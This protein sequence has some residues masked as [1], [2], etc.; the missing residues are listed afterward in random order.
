[1]AIDTGLIPLYEQKFS[2]LL[3]LKLQQIRAVLRGRVSEQAFAGAKL[4]SPL[5]QMDPIVM[6]A[7]EGRYAPV[8]ITPHTFTRRWV[9]PNDRSLVQMVDNFDLLKTNID[10]QSQ[11]VMDAAAAAARVYDDFIIAAFDAAATIGADAGSLSTESFD[12]AFSIA[13]TF[14]GSGG[15]LGLTVAKLNE[16]RRMLEHSHA[17]DDGGRPT[18]VI[19]SS[20]HADLRNQAQV[21]SSDFNRNGG[22][23]TNGV[24]TE[25][26][27]FDIVV[28]ERLPVASNIRKTFAFV[29]SGVCL[30]VWQDM[31]TKISQR[32]DLESQPWQ[33]YTSLS[34]GATRTQNGKVV[35]INCADTI[36]ADTPA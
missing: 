14:G 21:V 18:L 7:P 23:L 29:K 24:V 11:F 12:T 17:L 30:G 5:Q 1:M 9:A 28:S 13:D 3:E 22:V 6:G 32:D 8:K 16:A 15:S 34:A 35:R 2:T 19:G 26:M 4:A 27:G 25:F 36:G 20:Q 31:K 33:V 10:P